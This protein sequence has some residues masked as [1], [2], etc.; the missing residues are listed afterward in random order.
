MPDK[1]NFQCCDATITQF[2]LR[3]SSIGRFNYV[4]NPT[5]M[6]H[7]KQECKSIRD[8]WPKKVN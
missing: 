7:E 4:Q 3:G 1:N 6:K 2:E 5:T 8:D